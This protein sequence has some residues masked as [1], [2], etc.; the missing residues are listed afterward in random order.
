[1]VSHS[2][3]INEENILAIKLRL[4]FH[5]RK[6]HT[7]EKRDMLA[8]STALFRSGKSICFH[9][10]LFISVPTEV[11]VKRFAAT[12]ITKET[13]AK[14]MKLIMV[15]FYLVC[16]SHFSGPACTHGAVP[17]LHGTG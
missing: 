14:R 10:V 12:H 13:Q 17:H 3:K 9:T 5:T 15:Q 1:M 7:S 8:E 2:S 4:L 16:H 11:T 6:R